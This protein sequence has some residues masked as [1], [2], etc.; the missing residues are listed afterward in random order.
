MLR[1]TEDRTPYSLRRRLSAAMLAGFFFILCVTAIGMWNY[2]RDTANRT[3]DLLLDGS[4]IAILE[5]IKATENGI[6]VDFPPSALEILALAADDRV[7]YRIFDAA[8]NTITGENDLPLPDNFEPA[9]FHQFFDEEF[10]GAPFRFVVQAKELVGPSG[11]EWVNVQVGHTKQARN[12]IHNDLFTKGMIGLGVLAVA[13]M[14]FV[15][16]GINLAMRPL[17]GIEEDISHRAPTDLAPLHS[18]PP[19][20]IAGLISAINGFMR[21]LDTSRDN[22]QTF[23]ADVAHQVRTSLTAVGGQLERA[24]NHN[25]PDTVR[26]GLEKASEQTARTIHLTNQLLSHA[27]VVHRADVRPNEAINLVSLATSILEEVVRLEKNE[28]IDFEFD[29]SECRSG[30]EIGG[31]RISLREALRNLVDN[32]VTYSGPRA[33]ICLEL[34]DASFQGKPAVSLS[35]NDDGPGIPENKRSRV[36]ERFYTLGSR[37][38]SGLGLA[39]ADAVAKIHGGVLELGESRFGGLR[40][41]LILPIEQGDNHDKKE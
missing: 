2:A 30:H 1:K 21:R 16:L 13:G 37:H 39:I 36:V 15:R 20:E 22:A 29:F 35:V 8:G 41:A 27:M 26:Q 23:I 10:S 11:P 7:F 38:G 40:A 9:E 33:R 5:R 32:A 28:G 4:V 14:V 3:Y 17:A 6:L 25:D 18:E 19:R 34:V 31:D 24:L 12:F